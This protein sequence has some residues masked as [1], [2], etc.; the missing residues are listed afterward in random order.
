MTST[1]GFAR[2]RNLGAT[3]IE[4]ADAAA[5]LHMSPDA[6]QKLLERLRKAGL[7]RRV[8]HGLWAF[9]ERVDPLMLPDHLTAPFPSYV[10]LQTALYHHGLISQIPAVMYAVTL[11]RGRRV[12][13]DVGTFSLHHVSPALFDGFEIDPAGLKLAT[14]EKAL[15][16]VL[17]LSGKRTRE[18]STLPEV[19]FPA[20]F[21]WSELR[22]WMARIS[23]PR[24][25][26]IVERRIQALRGRDSSKN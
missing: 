16:D 26:T 25:R 1:E 9:I 19:E 13:T 14:P 23:S 18:F 8:F 20:G 3:I 6:A 21:R 5:A 24:D 11:G 10:S 17:Y 4:T 7:V 15:F 12:R 22:H 2:L